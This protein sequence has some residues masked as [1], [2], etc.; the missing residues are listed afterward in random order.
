LLSLNH[1]TV[2]FAMCLL[3]PDHSCLFYPGLFPNVRHHISFMESMSTYNILRTLIVL[4][5]TGS[6]LMLTIYLHIII[7]NHDIN[8]VAIYRNYKCQM[9]KTICI[10]PACYYLIHCRTIIKSNFPL[11]VCLRYLKY[12]QF[13]LTLLLQ[14]IPPLQSK[15]VGNNDNQSRQYCKPCRSSRMGRW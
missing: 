12:T 15:E 5:I 6:H 11:S 8:M 13:N 10:F 7:N 14:E 3:S 2:P 9:L 1:F 4:S